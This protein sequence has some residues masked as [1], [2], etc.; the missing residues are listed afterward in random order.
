MGQKQTRGKCVFCGKEFSKGGM[1]R[2]LLTCEARQKASTEA[3]ETADEKVVQPIFHLQI[4]EANGGDYWLQ[5][6][7]NGKALLRNL[8]HY[9]REIW[10]ECCGHLSAFEIG[11]YRYTKIHPA[12]K[13][14]D[15][16]S[17]NVAVE[18]LFK[19][20]MEIPYEYDF[21][22]TTELIIK[23]VSVRQGKPLISHPI[24]LMARNNAPEF[25]CVV[26]GQPATEL[27]IECMY[28]GENCEFV[29]S[30]LKNI[31]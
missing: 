26:C 16:K 29:Q 31:L 13:S 3:N 25:K 6:E 1:S 22:S 24:M 2:H 27:C 17:L 15:E 19:T 10:L 14:G 11:P 21:G 7:M 4:S 5:L 20:G 8:D 18:K 30:I 23:V 12:F 28:K 9:L